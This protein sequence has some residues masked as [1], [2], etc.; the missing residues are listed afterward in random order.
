MLYHNYKEIA[1]NFVEVVAFAREGLSERGLRNGILDVSR[2]QMAWVS[3]PSPPPLPRLSIVS[4]NTLGWR[5]LG[6]PH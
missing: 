1:S 2:S 6:H 3:Q 5:F 4:C